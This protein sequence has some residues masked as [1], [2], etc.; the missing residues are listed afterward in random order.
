MTE[1]QDV[2]DGARAEYNECKEVRRLLGYLWTATG[3]RAPD[4]PVRDLFNDDDPLVADVERL[5]IFPES[6]P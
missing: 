6:Q 4:M 3:N 5:A 1:P 2:L